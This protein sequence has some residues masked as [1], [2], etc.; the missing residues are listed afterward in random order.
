MRQSGWFAS[1]ADDRQHTPQLKNF[2]RVAPG[3]VDEH[4]VGK[5]RPVYFDAAPVLPPSY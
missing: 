2:D 3:D 5:K 4:V 1:S